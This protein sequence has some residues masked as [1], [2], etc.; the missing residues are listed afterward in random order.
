M[1]NSAPTQNNAASSSTFASTN[2]PTIINTQSDAA[3]IR[4]SRRA[5]AALRRP[6]AEFIEIPEPCES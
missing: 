4:S 1:P 6:V 5:L 3:A 2:L